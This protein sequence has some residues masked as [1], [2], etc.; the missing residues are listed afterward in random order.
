MRTLRPVVFADVEAPGSPFPPGHM[1][2]FGIRSIVLVPLIVSGRAAGVLLLCDGSPRRIGPREYRL[3]ELWMTQASA[4]LSN[5]KLYE[6][7]TAAMENERQILHQRA[8]LYEVNTRIQLAPSLNDAMRLVA[9]LAPQALGVDACIVC[10]AHPTPG[11]IHVAAITPGQSTDAL[12]EDMVAQCASCAG[13]I[14][15][16]S[17]KHVEDMREHPVRGFPHMGS[18]LFVPLTARGAT[19]G[20]LVLLRAA[21]GPFDA[22]QVRVAELFAAR[23][24]AKI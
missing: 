18:A 22:E 21:R 23:A 16:A 15:G 7:M 8:M 14:A 10:L 13:V 9:E 12:R 1:G 4:I 2:R 6:G 24:A 3:A 20:L 17:I 11:H 19:L 5:R